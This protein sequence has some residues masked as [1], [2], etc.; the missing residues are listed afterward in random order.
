M[1]IT[2]IDKNLK[3]SSVKDLDAEWRNVREGVFSGHGVFYSEEENLYR[4][5]PKKIADNIMRAS[6]VYLFNW[7]KNKICYR[8]SVR[9][10]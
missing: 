5:M 2:E 6:I 8:F 10:S 4:R 7:W 9:C 1:D 3:L